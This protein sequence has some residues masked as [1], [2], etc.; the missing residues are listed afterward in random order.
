[1]SNKWVDRYR[2][3]FMG[4]PRSLRQRAK[5]WA[6][7]KENLV[8]VDVH[9][10]N[11]R[12]ESSVD[13]EFLTLDY[14]FDDM[15]GEY[16]FN[17]A[18]GGP[19]TRLTVNGAEWVYDDEYCMSGV[20]TSST[21]G[22]IRGRADSITEYVKLNKAFTFDMWIR[23]SDF[24]TTGPPRIFSYA[25][26][27][28]GTTGNGSTTAD[29]LYTRN[30][31]L[32]QGSIG[33]P[34]SGNHL[35]LRTRIKNDGA[36]ASNNGTSPSPLVASNELT[37]NSLHHVA[38]SVRG[39]NDGDD[40]SL[41]AVTLYVDGAEAESIVHSIDTDYDDLFQN[42]GD[43]DADYLLSLFDEVSNPG[44]N[45]GRGWKGTIYRFRFWR[46]AMSPIMINELYDV[47]PRGALNCNWGGGS[48]GLGELP[49]QGGNIF[50]PP[51]ALPD[52]ATV[53]F[54]DDKDIDV[55]ANDVV[56]GDKFFRVQSLQIVSAPA[57]GTATVV[58]G[59][60]N[61]SATD[62]ADTTPQAVDTFTYKV[63]DNANLFTTGTVNVTIASGPGD[64][65]VPS[66]PFPGGTAYPGRY[67]K[68]PGVNGGPNPAYVS[69]SGGPATGD[70]V[71]ACGID[72]VIPW[73]ST[74][75]PNNDYYK[76]DEFGDQNAADVELSGFNLAYPGIDSEDSGGI[77]ITQ[78]GT[79]E[80]FVSYKKIQIRA[81][82]VTLKNFVVD[83][84][85]AG[86]ANAKS[87]IWQK[88]NEIGYDDNFW[89]TN[90]FADSGVKGPCPLYATVNSQGDY[91]WFERSPG[92]MNYAIDI[93]QQSGNSVSGTVIQDGIVA[94]GSSKT[95][96]AKSHTTVGRCEIK[97][98]GG[99]SLEYNGSY[100]TV[101]GCWI[102]HNGMLKKSHSDGFQTQGGAYHR[103]FGNFMDMPNTDQNFKPYKSNAT[104][105]ASCT[106]TNHANLGII[107]NWL[108]GGNH[109]VQAGE[110]AKWQDFSVSGG[111]AAS[112][113]GTC[114]FS[115]NG[116]QFSATSEAARA[117]IAG[118][119]LMLQKRVVKGSSEPQ[120]RDVPSNLWTLVDN[121]TICLSGDST[122]NTPWEPVTYDPTD[123]FAGPDG[124][125]STYGTDDVGCLCPKETHWW[126]FGDYAAYASNPN[127]WAPNGADCDWFS[128]GE[129]CDI[130]FRPTT[131]G[132]MVFSGMSGDGED[133]EDAYGQNGQYRLV[134]SSKCMIIGRWSGGSS[135]NRY[136]PKH[137][138]GIIIADNRMGSD[139][140]FGLLKLS[141]KD[142]CHGDFETDGPSN[143][144]GTLSSTIASGNV[145]DYTGQLIG[146]ATGGYSPD[147]NQQFS[148]NPSVWKMNELCMP[149]SGTTYGASIDRPRSQ[150]WCSEF[151][152]GMTWS[153]PNFTT[154]GS[155]DFC[156]DPWC[157]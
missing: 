122:R 115:L 8:P 100:I 1:M 133:P 41:V 24:T 99:D 9:T 80:N 146:S 114:Y 45:A 68:R 103:M 120:W 93:N 56:Y 70:L 131:T 106:K 89:S 74:T 34:Y 77:V 16:L 73:E 3:K 138:S 130:L 31:S 79:Y 84:C 143:E 142:N 51:S 78:S 97:E 39:V 58:N 105:I 72:W 144:A 139:F 33:S 90:K 10:A 88:Q 154:T 76:I 52:Y 55:L 27:T 43:S 155:A 28:S 62:Y 123:P 156:P 129:A 48:G 108:N 91:E 37:L 145:W 110:G 13:Q 150:G 15:D 92:Q 57:S 49:Q 152:S 136:H 148:D 21:Y 157:P 98:G 5:A 23:P 20:S 117:I 66:I 54:G 35:Q 50:T 107:G 60:I 104:Y 75:G 64:T 25:P 101:S 71:D 6:Y 124:Y 112:A 4:G 128:Q 63:K 109:N 113:D 119:D 116:P 46:Q 69:F 17:K 36:A 29:A 126:D 53:Y 96:L 87:L 132:N 118:P 7:A 127:N 85:L 125:T 42:W 82:N 19:D 26:A 147:Y 149:A 94:W 81:H 111:V 83:A 38:I 22:S 95:I 121:S 30:V 153:D 65:F 18:A 32:L 151:D 44:I 134:N 86:D 47:G 137:V 141:D 61:Y 40:G 2:K 59:K 12:E 11:S 14:D 67:E 135:S 102:H 140:N